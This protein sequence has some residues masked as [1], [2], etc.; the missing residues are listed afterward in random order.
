M[1]YVQVGETCAADQNCD[2]GLA[3]DACGNGARKCIRVQ[4]TP[5]TSKVKGLPFNK[6][7]WLT[8]H[9]SFSIVG[10]K[11][12]SGSNLISPRNQQDSVTSQLNV[13]FLP[14]SLH[15]WWW[16]LVS[17]FS[18]FLVIDNTENTKMPLSS[19]SNFIFSGYIGFRCKI[20]HLFGIKIHSTG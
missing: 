9:N 5:P 8:T 19:N 20:I 2:T 17:L 15:R 13:S 16:L 6:Y 1:L 3:C 12:A 11:S 18:R 10:A 14:P 4:P 7:S